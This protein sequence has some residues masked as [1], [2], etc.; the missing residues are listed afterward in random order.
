MN[1]EISSE[2]ARVGDRF[3]TTVVD[4]V[5]ARGLEVIPAGSVVTGRVTSVNRASR[6]IVF[7]KQPG[8]VVSFEHAFAAS[9]W[10]AVRAFPDSEW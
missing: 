8:V 4:P 7:S 6:M 5:Y 3:T 9:A 10:I 1:E 2:N